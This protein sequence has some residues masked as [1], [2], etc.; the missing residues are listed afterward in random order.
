[1]GEVIPFAC[2]RVG[3]YDVSPFTMLDYAGELACLI[4]FGG[5]NLRCV[6]CHNPQMVRS[7]GRVPWAD[8]RAFLRARQG[9]LTAVV[10]TG[11]EATLHPDIVALAREIKTMGFKVKLDTNGT[12]PTVVQTLLTENLLDFVALDYK[13][14][15]AAFT[16]VTGVSEARWDAFSQTLDML[17]AQK[18]VGFEVRTTVHTDVLAESDV[19]AIR[20]DLATRGYTGPY[21]VQNFR[22]CEAT[23]G[24]LPPQ[25]AVLSH[26]TLAEPLPSGRVSVAFRNF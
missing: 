1:M 9:K 18:T 23:L 3:V 4:W 22:P 21:F 5:C 19:M 6:Y 11:G 8:V 7:V 24:N 17:I 16:R 15:R 25:T 10:L 26:A 20:D 13:A 14:P 2:P 12:R